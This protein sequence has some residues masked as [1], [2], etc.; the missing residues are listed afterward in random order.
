MCKFPTERNVEKILWRSLEKRRYSTILFNINDNCPEWSATWS[1]MKCV[2]TNLRFVVT[3]LI[4]TKMAPHEVQFPF[5]YIYFEIF[6]NKNT[7]KTIFN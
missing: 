2:I 4:E 6:K 3:G 1:E 5:Y 7:L